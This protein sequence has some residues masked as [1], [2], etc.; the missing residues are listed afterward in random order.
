MSFIEN[1]TA[2]SLNLPEDEFEQYMSGE[3]VPT[4]T[5]DSALMMYEASVFFNPY[6]LS[7]ALLFFSLL[8]YILPLFFFKGISLMYE[9]LVALDDMHKRADS[10]LEG[11]DL[12]KTKMKDFLVWFLCSL[13][14]SVAIL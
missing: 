3:V 1:M 8:K 6:Y 14:Q 4:S 11:A 5:W 2:Q 10:V 9:H 7:S 12:L 13:S